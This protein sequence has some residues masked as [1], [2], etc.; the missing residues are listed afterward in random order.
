MD[1]RQE[2]KNHPGDRVIYQVEESRS[3]K[4]CQAFCPELVIVGFGDTPETAKEAL[5]A[6]VGSYLEDCDGLGIL[7]EVLIEAGFYDDG[8]SWISNLVTPVKDPKI[9]FFGGAQGLAEL[10]EPEA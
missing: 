2:E 6:E 10:I 1:R 3:G 8:G 5:R 9:R 7:D 4:T